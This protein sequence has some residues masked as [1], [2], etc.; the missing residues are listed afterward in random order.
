M[1][2][3]KKRVKLKKKKKNRKLQLK[4]KG[5]NQANLDEPHKPSLI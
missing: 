5:K 1:E 4:K 2:N 3:H